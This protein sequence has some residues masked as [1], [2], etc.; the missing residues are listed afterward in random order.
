MNV[1]QP[2][3]HS[4]AQVASSVSVT[5]TPQEGTVVVVSNT[6]SGLIHVEVSNVHA[7]LGAVVVIVYGAQPS[8]AV[9]EGG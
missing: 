6:H 7:G 8:V 9:D 3:G 1:A 4:V 2:A 5:G